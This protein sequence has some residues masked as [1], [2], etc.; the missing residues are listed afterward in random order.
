MRLMSSRQVH[1]DGLSGAELN[2]KLAGFIQRVPEHFPQVRAL[3]AQVV[4]PRV[5]P[6][7]AVAPH[8]VH[9][10]IVFIPRLA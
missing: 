10:L 2:Q 7:P 4:T 6:A 9:L 8:P 3:P 1:G 5:S